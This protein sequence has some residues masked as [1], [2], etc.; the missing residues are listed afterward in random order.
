MSHD[1]DDALRGALRRHAEEA[2]TYVDLDEVRGRADR[3]RRRR[4]VELLAA[5]VVAVGVVVGLG[6]VVG[7]LRHGATPPPVT[8][9]SPTPGALPPLAFTR[10]DANAQPTGAAQILLRVNGA[11]SV[12]TTTSGNA[13]LLGWFGPDHRTLVWGD[14]RNYGFRE[15][16][17]YAVTVDADGRATGAPALLTVPGSGPLGAGLPFVVPGGPIQLWVPT[18]PGD[19]KSPAVLKTISADLD[20]VLTRSLP[21]GEV[22]IAITRDHISFINGDSRVTAALLTLG[23]VSSRLR[24][25]P[26]CVRVTGEATSLD[27]TAMALGCGGGTVD[28]VRLVDGNVTHLPAVPETNQDVYPL[29]MWW[30]PAGGIHA[31]TTPTLRADYT[32]VHSWDLNGTTW[33]PGQDG[34]L[35]RSYPDG[36]PSVRYVKENASPGNNGRWVVE[37][38][39]EVDLGPS[40]GSIT[41]R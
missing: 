40:D 8:T 3:I 28:V 38:S 29:A 5:G 39:P 23:G 26:T 4:T 34:V 22:P 14:Q 15:V 18:N 27:G 30:D 12:L 24:P 31:A 10:G 6:A 37:S 33:A 17:L 2:P 36:A 41:V 35:F 20:R 11:L 1:L 13:T 16:T 19:G 25:I 21:A 7:T 32:V 9:Q